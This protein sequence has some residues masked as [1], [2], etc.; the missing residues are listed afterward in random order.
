[1]LLET[2]D[3]PTAQQYNSNSNSN[4]S[5]RCCSPDGGAGSSAT[6]FRVTCESLRFR[7]QAPVDAAPDGPMS[8]VGAKCDVET[9]FIY[10]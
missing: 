3:R 4:S 2:S 1:M 6:R 5:S 10:I 8:Q 7:L 9:W